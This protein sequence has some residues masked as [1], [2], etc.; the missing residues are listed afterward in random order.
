MKK[1]SP[2]TVRHSLKFVSYGLSFV[3]YVFLMTH[4]GCGKKEKTAEK[5]SE[6]KDLLRAAL[7]K[8]APKPVEESKPVD[9]Q[10]EVNT[11]PTL[12]VTPAPVQP[13]PIQ[14]PPVQPP[15]VKPFTAYEL[16]EKGVKSF[17]A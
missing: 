15:P 10:Q 14:P 2:K 9:Q 13:T 1:S 4:C 7:E 16:Y 12:T 3:V 11:P 17:N 6:I 8:Q 5:S